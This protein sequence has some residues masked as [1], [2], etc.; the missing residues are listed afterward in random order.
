MSTAGARLTVFILLF[1][2]SFLPKIV[3]MTGEILGEETA[4]HGAPQL[5]HF[6]LVPLALGLDLFFLPC[7]V[8]FLKRLLGAPDLERARLHLHP[9]EQL[10]VSPPWVVR[11]LP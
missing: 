10:H 3:F 2:I 8:L 5:F 6:L 4:A 1:M 7:L 11:V 9:Q